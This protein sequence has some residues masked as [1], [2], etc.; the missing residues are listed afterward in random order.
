MSYI[1]STKL[2]KSK[3]GIKFEILGLKKK[4]IG[5][6]TSAGGVGKGYLLKS[7]FTDTKNFLFKRPLK[8]AYFSLEDDIDIVNDKFSEMDIVHKNIHFYFNKTEFFKLVPNKYDLIIVDTF[9]RF[10]KGQVDENSN[11]EMSYLYDTILDRVRELN[12]ALLFIHHTNKTSRDKKNGSFDANSLRGAGSL[13][14]DARLVIGLEEVKKG[15]LKAS[16]LKINFESPNSQVYNRN[17][18]GGLEIVKEQGRNK[19]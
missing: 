14:D 9:S 1:D 17:A 8:I 5:V 15:V 12:C 3:T 13:S 6:L 7:F 18:S 4:T 10:N 11:S 16:T 2:K 19:C